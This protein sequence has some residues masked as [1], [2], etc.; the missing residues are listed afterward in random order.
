MKR[1]SFALIAMLL[2]SP[3]LGCAADKTVSGDLVYQQD[4][5]KADALGDF[6]FASPED[7][8]RVKVGDRWAMEYGND[9]RKSEY[10]PPH[11]SPLY[12]GLI[13]DIKVASFRLEYDVQQR[14]QTGN[15]RDHCVFFNFEDPANFFYTH[16]AKKSDPHAHQIM[17]VDDAPR[18]AI[19]KKGTDGYDWASM[20]QWHHVKVIREADSGLIAIYV[21]DMDTPIMTTHSKAHDIGYV[22]FGSF[23]DLG[24]VSNIKLWAPKVIRENA[25][26]FKQK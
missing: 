7:F 6:V 18:K 25:P 16:I 20:D 5:A 15:H 10:K 13:R 14:S 12:I 3:G 11:R 24:R 19:T 8:R 26:F 22:G 21:N 4:F 17:N 2:L 1:F 23:D 9:S